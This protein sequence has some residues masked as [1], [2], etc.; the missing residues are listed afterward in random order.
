[1]PQNF[2]G[3]DRDQVFLLPPSVDDWL[4]ADHFARF[5]I[6]IVEELDLAAFYAEYRADGQGRP[7]HDP[8]MMVALLVYGYARGQRSSRVIERGVEFGALSERVPRG[9]LGAR[10]RARRRRSSGWL[11]G[12]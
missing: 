1:M 5:V 6:A 10:W 3:C 8:A 7:A 9:D 4:P 12:V 2:L 11:G